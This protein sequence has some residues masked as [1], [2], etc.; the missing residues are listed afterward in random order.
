MNQLL[1]DELKIVPANGAYVVWAKIED[2]D[3]LPGML[4]IGNRPTSLFSDALFVCAQ[5]LEKMG[6]NRAIEDD[7]SLDIITSH[8]IADGA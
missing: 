3:W 4:N 6:Q 1:K 5:E 2:G 8:N 7:L